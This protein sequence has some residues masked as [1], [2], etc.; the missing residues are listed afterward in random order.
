MEHKPRKGQIGSW[1]VI[2]KKYISEAI[3]S[4]WFIFVLLK[5]NIISLKIKL[6]STSFY[7]Q[8]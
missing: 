6:L 2:W 8:H 3:L 7:R 4:D 5:L 1:P